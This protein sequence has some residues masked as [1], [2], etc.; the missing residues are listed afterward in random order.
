MNEGDLA[1][2]VIETFESLAIPYFITGSMASIALG[3]ARYTNDIDIIADIPSNKI[4]PLLTAFP[5]P[6]YY[7]SE[8]AVREAVSQRFQF[9]II[10]PRSGLKVDV[11]LPAEDAF[12]RMRMS[13]KIQLNVDSDTVGWFSS[14]EDVILKKLV[15]FQLGGSEKHLRDICGVLLVQGDRIDQ[16]YLDNWA[17]Q[18]GVTEELELVRRKLRQREE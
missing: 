15:F 2:K 14:A 10:H 17:E 12:D 9:N 8:S 18:L 5:A 4:R 13:R 3:E 16:A 7:L 11:M 1:R 6:E